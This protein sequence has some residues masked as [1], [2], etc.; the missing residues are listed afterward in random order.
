MDK[1]SFLERVTL[2]KVD[3]ALWQEHV[4][5][6]YFALNFVSQKVVL[7]VACGTGYGT[8]LISKTA[9]LVVGVDVSRD[10]LTYAMNHYGKTHIGF[11]LADARNLPFQGSAFDTVVS[12]ETIEH[13][14]HPEVFLQEIRS[15]LK[16]GGKLIVST[17][18]RK[19]TTSIKGKPAN[20]FHLNEFY[21]DEFS[22]LLGIF[23]P[24]MQFYG[25]CKYTLKDQLFR[26]LDTHLPASSKVLFKTFSRIALK[27]STPQAKNI[28]T[29]DPVYRVKK[30][31]NF[32]PIC[33]PRFFVAVVDNEKQ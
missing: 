6:Y 32:Y 3:Y 33:I 19:I 22:Q 16:L 20:P 8:E 4:S 21:A 9:D 28:G 14:I 2:G 29:I 5:R 26:I 13:L 24:K 18:N 25:Q 27:P 30:I 1:T 17:P 15:I 11:V 7:D 10:A 31:R 12:F 23:S